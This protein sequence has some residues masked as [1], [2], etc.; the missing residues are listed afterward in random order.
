METLPAPQRCGGRKGE[1][2]SEARLREGGCAASHTMSPPPGAEQ[3]RL[4]VDLS[5]TT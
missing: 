3:N 5:T 2:A 1:K 4:A